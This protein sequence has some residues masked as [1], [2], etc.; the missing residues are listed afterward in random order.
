MVID[1]IPPCKALYK[2]NELLLII[3]L[4]RT[5]ITYLYHAVTAVLGK[6]TDPRNL[7]TERACCRRQSHVIYIGK[8]E[9]M[10]G[11]IIIIMSLLCLAV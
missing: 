4:M 8:G 7:Y 1:E 5:N 10:L 9:A 6:N 3:I 2:C 11:Y